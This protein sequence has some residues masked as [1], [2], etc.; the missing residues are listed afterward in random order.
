MRAK[1]ISSAAIATAL[2][3]S[4][5]CSSS[6]IQTDK[7]IKEERSSSSQTAPVMV[8]ATIRREDGTP[9][10]NRGLHLITISRDAK[11]EMNKVDQLLS[12][13]KNTDENGNLKF[14][15]SRDNMVGA[16]E[17]SFGLNPSGPYDPP[18]VIRRKD[19]KD[20]LSFN[21]DDKTKSIEMGEV[22]ILLR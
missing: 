17:F 4:A 12:V 6:S 11:G 3:L 8:T 5:G 21:A 10:R 18:M 22:V 15:L 19:A 20:I 13:T 16:K 1:L 2:A 9:L 7:S 14:E